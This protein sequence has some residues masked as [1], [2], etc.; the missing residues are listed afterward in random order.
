MAAG[1]L[2]FQGIAV[3]I[4]NVDV[5]ILEKASTAGAPGSPLSPTVSNQLI[6]LD[7]PFEIKFDWDQIAGSFL[8]NGGHWKFD[9]YL[10]LMGPGE[11]TV[12]GGHFSGTTPASATN[13]SKTYTLSVNQNTVAA[14]TYRITV[15]QQ[16][17][18]LGQPRALAM[19]GDIGLVK[20]YEE[21]V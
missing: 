21:Q 12:A 13:G 11:A 20:F 3:D 17:Y 18:S 9:V 15:A 7:Q 1:N 19:F 10:E 2:E 5:N 16:F 14:G 8:L 6:Q 4:Q